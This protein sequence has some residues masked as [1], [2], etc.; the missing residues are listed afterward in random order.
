MSIFEKGI[1]DVYLSARKRGLD[2]VERL[3]RQDRYPY[4]RDLDTITKGVK[5]VSQVSLGLIDVPL[6]QIT[7]TYTKIRITSYNVCYTKLLRYV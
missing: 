5:V 4:L 3:E 2:E 1:E 7:G 6:R